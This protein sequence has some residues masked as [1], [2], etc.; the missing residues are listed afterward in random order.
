MGEGLLDEGGDAE[1]LNRPLNGQ[2][3]RFREEAE[4]EKRKRSESSNL[5][6]WG[7]EGTGTRDTSHGVAWLLVM[8][9]KKKQEK[10]RSTQKV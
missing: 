4:A 6:G 5:R 1:D 7:W 10:G 8:Y 3:S 2:F 9:G